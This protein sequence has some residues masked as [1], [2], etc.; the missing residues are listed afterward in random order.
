MPLGA[1]LNSLIFVLINV[2]V[3]KKIG[4]FLTCKWSQCLEKEE[5]STIANL[6]DLDFNTDTSFHQRH[7]FVL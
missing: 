5:T 3:K 7:S 1:L 2:F 6:N 4:H